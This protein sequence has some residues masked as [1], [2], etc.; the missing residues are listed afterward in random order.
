M[1]A[2]ELRYRQLTELAAQRRARLEESRR[3]WKFFWDVGEEEA[4]MREQERLLSSED[5]GRDPTSSRHLLS[6]HAAFRHELSGRAGPLRQ[7]MDEGRA[8]V[9]E[10]HSGAPRVAERLRELERRWRELGELAERRERRLRDAAALFQFQAEAA[11]VEGWLE[12]ALRLAGS[13]ELGR[14]EFST[15]S[16]ARQHREVQEEVRGHRPAIAALREQLEA[17]PANMAEDPGVAARLPALE[18]RYEELCEQTERRR[19]E[20]Q[21]ALGLY[22]MRSEADACG[23]W[24]AEKEKWLQAL[25]V[26]DKLEDLEVVQQR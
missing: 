9:A 12:D 18:R 26:P 2:L 14:D 8:L 16:L 5:V 11:D 7:A 23:L 15:R 25:L 22:T 21:D 10:G 1:A 6:Q 19:R 4:W 24:V 3:F 17:L 13:P 20:L